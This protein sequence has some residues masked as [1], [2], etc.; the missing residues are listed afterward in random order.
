MDR[1]RGARGPVLLYLLTGFANVL[2]FGYQFV[3]PRFLRP[4]EF[5]ILTQLFGILLVESIG[6]QV[7]QTAMAKLAAQYR[8]RDDDAALHVFVRRWLVRI[9]TFGAPPALLLALFAGPLS[10]AIRVSTASVV[11][12]GITLFLAIVLTFTMGLLQGLGRFVWLGGDLVA[13]AGAR[14][15]LGT[16]LVLAGAGVD[17]AFAGASAALLVGLLISLIP[18]RPLFKSARAATPAAHLARDETRFFLLA[19]LVLLAY[20]GLTNVDAVMARALMSADDAG[21]YSAAITMAK[22]ILFAPVA[23]GYLVLERTARAHERGHDTDRPLLIALGF[24]LAT[25]GAVALAYIIRPGLFAAIIVGPQYP[26]AAEVI[27][28][29]GLAA[30]CNALLSIWN[31]YFIGRGRMRIG[32]LLGLALI[33]E[34]ALLSTYAH[35]A[36]TA[37]LVVTGVAFAT[38]LCAVAT[39][40]IDR[41]ARRPTIPLRA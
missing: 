11:L 2:A 41:L 30:L 28:V 26:R 18:L 20:A 37:T 39:F 16:G 9:V 31:A 8:A 32:L 12:L 21:N 10:Q 36:L 6:T 29:Y 14:L 24:V 7:I 38:Q 19:A 40:A 22:V 13:Q 17:G 33:V 3:M 35:D 25:S 34:V 1:L 5:A 23:V 15:A 27:P 4:G